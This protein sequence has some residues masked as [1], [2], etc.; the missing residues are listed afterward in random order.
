MVFDIS[1]GPQCF[2]CLG[3]TQGGAY[4]G[5]PR[6]LLLNDGLRGLVWGAEVGGTG[7]EFHLVE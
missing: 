1:N 4:T 3:D 7:M 5:K 2:S 6:A